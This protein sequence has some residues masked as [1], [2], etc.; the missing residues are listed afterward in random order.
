M[1]LEILHMKYML[2]REGHSKFL[3]AIIRMAL[4]QQLIEYT[5]VEL[6]TH[7]N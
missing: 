6:L 7:G 5:C 2:F 3:V 4:F 1:T